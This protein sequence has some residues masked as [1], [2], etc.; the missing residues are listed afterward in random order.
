MC[1]SF[2]PWLVELHAWLWQFGECV[3]GLLYLMSLVPP[4][5]WHFHIRLPA[6]N[7]WSPGFP[8][9]ELLVHNVKYIHQLNELVVNEPGVNNR[10]RRSEAV[11]EI[12]LGICNSFSALCKHQLVFGQWTLESLV[13]SVGIW[14]RLKI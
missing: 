2:I 9:L 12:S 7:S 13:S 10:A 1:L 6:V 4:P 14:I 5:C 3:M 8:W 11:T